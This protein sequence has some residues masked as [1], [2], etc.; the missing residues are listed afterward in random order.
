MD[1]KWFEE[2]AESRMAACLDLMLGRK[3]QEYSRDGDRLSNFK[4]Q[5]KMKGETPEKALLGNWMKHLSS[6]LD[7]IEDIENGRPIV[8]DQLR[9]KITDSINYHLLL[10]AL[11]EERLGLRE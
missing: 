8:L 5:A 4:R 9:E 2:V 6:I 3:A 10:E 1:S 11:I 7:A